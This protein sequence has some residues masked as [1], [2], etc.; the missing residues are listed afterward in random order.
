MAKIDNNEFSCLKIL[1]ATPLPFKIQFRAVIEELLFVNHLPP[2]LRILVPHG[3]AG[4]LI[5]SAV[6]AY[7]ELRIHTKCKNK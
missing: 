1:S 6:A 5:K 3:D 2:Y 7:T 4:L